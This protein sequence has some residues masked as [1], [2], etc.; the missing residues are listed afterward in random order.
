MDGSDDPVAGWRASVACD[1]LHRHAERLPVAGPAGS[2]DPPSRSAGRS[3]V[4]LPWTPGQPAEGDLARR[5]GRMPVH[6]A[7]GAGPL[8]VAE[9]GRRSG[10]DLVR[11]TR[12]P[13]SGIDWR[14]PQE[15]WRP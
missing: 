15:T 8:L 12:L 9:P 4:L 1:R 7:P 10:D 13:A 11:A 2:G 5:P 6:E 14:Y 3:S